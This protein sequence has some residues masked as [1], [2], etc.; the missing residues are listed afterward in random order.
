MKEGILHPECGKIFMRGKPEK[1]PEDLLLYTHQQEAIAVAAKSESYVVT[2]GTG[3]GKS[4]AFFIP[5][6]NRILHEKKADPGARTRAVS[7]I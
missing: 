7:S 5:I 4:L 1:R 3:S 2:T 6:V